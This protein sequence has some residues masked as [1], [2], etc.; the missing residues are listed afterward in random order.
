MIIVEGRDILRHDFHTHSLQSAC[1]IHTVI[2]IMDI[3]ARKG[4]ETVNICDHGSAAGRNMNFGVI[5]NPRRTPRLSQVAVEGK[6]VP[7]RLL[8]GIEANIL[9]KGNTDLPLSKLEGSSHQ[10]SFISAGFHSYASELKKLHDPQANFDTLVRYVEQYP[11]D[12]LTHPCI[13]T[14]PLPITELVQLAKQHHFALE[15]NNT[16]LVVEKTNL[17]LLQKM[18]EEGLAQEATL[19]CNSD[20]HTWYE[21][22][23]CGAVRAFVKDRLHHEMEE[24]FPL[25]F[26]PWEDVVDRFERIDG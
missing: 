8:A 16:N 22:F 20:G 21:M 1:G 26:G 24:V 7:V 14:F 9:D 18:I 5:A 13:A 2:E 23:E 10:F 15:V 4:V 17:D 6:A 11:I 25:N 12:I 3:A 19:F